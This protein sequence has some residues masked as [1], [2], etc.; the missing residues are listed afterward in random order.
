MLTPPVGV[1][2]FVAWQIGKLRID[3]IL[4]P[5]IP[6]YIVLLIDILLISYLPQIS[7]WLPSVLK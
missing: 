4:K 2:L 6:F 5:L 7:L 1:N 3:Q